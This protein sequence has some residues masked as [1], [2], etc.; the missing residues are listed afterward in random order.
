[1]AGS[2]A[3]NSTLQPFLNFLL[4]RLPL[5]SPTCPS[6]SPTTQPRPRRYRFHHDSE[7]EGDDTDEATQRSVVGEAGN[8]DRRR[9]AGPLQLVLHLHSR[10]KET[11][12]WPARPTRPRRRRREIQMH[13]RKLPLSPGTVTRAKLTALEGAHP[14]RCRPFSPSRRYHK[15][16]LPPI[17]ARAMQ[18]LIPPPCSRL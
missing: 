10:P 7:K 2:H 11:S 4:S 12:T 6:S 17:S 5:H 9:L 8:H 15:C 13:E 14:R 3:Y 16:A 18:P 1:M